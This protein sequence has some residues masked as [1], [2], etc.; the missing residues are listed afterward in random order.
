[1]TRPPWKRKRRRRAV[2][3][4]GTGAVRPLVADGPDAPLDGLDER[5]FQAHVKAGL[6]QRGY[7]VFEFPYMVWTLAGWPDLTFFHPSRPGTL[8]VWE[9]KTQTGAL[10]S[11]QGPVLAHMQTVAGIDARLVRPL[12]WQQLKERM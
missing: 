5:T 10:S 9:L 2:R 11:A 12:D 6:E 7:H 4:T 3:P 1:M 8:Y